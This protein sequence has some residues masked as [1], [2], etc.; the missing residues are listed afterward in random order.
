MSLSERG[1]PRSFGAAPRRRRIPN[2]LNAERKPRRSTLRRATLSMFVQ[3]LAG[4]EVEVEL[5]GGARVRGTLESAQDDLGLWLRPFRFVHFP[6][7][8]PPSAC[9][10]FDRPV[11]ASAAADERHDAL[12][13]RAL[14]GGLHGSGES[15]ESVRRRSELH[16]EAVRRNCETIFLSGTF[17]RS[18]ETPNVDVPAT[19]EQ[20]QKVLTRIRGGFTRTMRK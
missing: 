8:L 3:A 13:Q 20:H 14:S 2:S 17:V 11:R 6:R 18:I 7:D 4:S 19:L 15:V 5:R 1:L 12:D 9:D 10:M 16:D